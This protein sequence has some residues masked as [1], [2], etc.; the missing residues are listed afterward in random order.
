[1]TAAVANGD[2]TCSEMW[3]RLLRRSRLTLP[4]SFWVWLLQS[5]GSCL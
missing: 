4:L 3:I 2:H 5:P 1:M